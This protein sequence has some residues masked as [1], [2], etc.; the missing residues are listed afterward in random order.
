MVLL[1]CILITTVS[2]ATG[3]AAPTTPEQPTSVHHGDK[4][5]VSTTDTGLTL[6]RRPWWPAGFNAYQLG[7]D[8]SVNRGCGATVDLD[9]YF[10]QLPAR[11]L[12]RINLFSMFV[13]NK[14]TGLID[15]APLD[16][17]FAAAKRHRQMVL[18]VL[19]GSSGD[20]EDHEFK[21]RDWYVDGWQ[22]EESPGGMTFAD[23]M[24]TAVTR[25]KNE[26]TIAGWELVGEPEAS[27]CGP[28]GCAWQNRQCPTGG[29]QVLRTFF[30]TAGA[31]LHELDP[32]RI[33]F[34]GFIGGDQCGFEGDDLS[35]VGA[36]PQLDVLDF[37]DYG[38]ETTLYGPA[39][40]NLPTRIRQARALRKPLMVNEIGIHA[41]SC[42]PTSTRA[43]QF[44]SRIAEQRELGTAGALLWA[45]VPDP[46][47][48]ECTYD[49]GFDDP[50]WQIVADVVD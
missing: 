34:A 7:T 41:G 32:D 45:F 18:P 35:T 29:A 33:L 30:D 10:G 26:S 22:H 17:V 46:R 20:C 21:E 12:T 49:I 31:R 37:H 44:R 13:V 36:S 11:A 16:R 2:L 24:T 15:F 42:L 40:S 1:G 4:G 47:P 6:D 48:N 50:A 25:W 39:G 9:E 27:V 14:N 38:S 5:R 3:C 19:T 28:G 23:W 8:W 43:A